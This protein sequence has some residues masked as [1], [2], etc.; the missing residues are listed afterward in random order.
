MSKR[1][2]GE[3]RRRRD[4]HS[5]D[6]DRN[7][8]S[9]LNSPFQSSFNIVDSLDR[10]EK[11][12][13]KKMKE[14]FEKYNKPFKEDILLT[15]EDLSC[16]DENGTWNV[17]SKYGQKNTI[18]QRDV[19]N[20]VQKLKENNN[21]SIVGTVVHGDSGC[22][23]DTTVNIPLKYSK[24]LNTNCN[25]TY[26][27]SDDENDKSIELHSEEETNGPLDVK[28][29]L[30]PLVHLSDTRCGKMYI[31]DTD[32]LLDLDESVSSSKII[33]KRKEG[34]SFSVKYS[35]IKIRR[36]SNVDG[37]RREICQKYIEN[38]YCRSLDKSTLEES[39]F[40][41]VKKFIGRHNNASMLNGT[42]SVQEKN[43]CET[44]D[45]FADDDALNSSDLG[46]VSLADYYPNMIECLS[47]LMDFPRKEM[48]AANIIRY[49]RHHFWFAN[50]HKLDITKAKRTMFRARNLKLTIGSNPKDTPY[51]SYA[52]TSSI[53]PMVMDDFNKSGIIE[54]RKQNVSTRYPDGT[55][56]LD[57][58]K[59]HVKSPVVLETFIF[60]NDKTSKFGE[61]RYTVPENVK[62][63]NE[64]CTG[65][66][67]PSSLL[68]RNCMVE[69]SPSKL[70]PEAWVK[71][72]HQMKVASKSS[73]LFSPD[74]CRLLKQPHQVQCT[75]KRRHS[76]ST[77]PSQQ[78]SVGMPLNE[79]TAF[80]TLYKKL[81]MQDSYPKFLPTHARHHLSETVNALI[82]SPGSIRGKR[83]ANEDFSV[84]NFKRFRMSG[85][86]EPIVTNSQYHFSRNWNSKPSFSPQMKN[87]SDLG[88]Y[89]DSTRLN[90]NLG[91]RSFS[92]RIM[93]SRSSPLSELYRGSSKSLKMSSPS[94][95]VNG[96][97]KSVHRKLNYT[98]DCG[99]TAGDDTVFF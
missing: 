52:K 75:L 68:V 13:Q 42:L 78:V 50:K 20:K 5:E 22:Y 99:S 59:S 97:R 18:P 56:I 30:I 72:N 39:F 66:S 31:A 6:F 92:P 44:I 11:I 14:I 67:H 40:M 48:A 26:I 19:Q 57:L 4:R 45:E 74:K 60:N 71:M 55:K 36:D 65:L 2:L 86:F 29:S 12:F 38:D 41:Q 87:G 69:K 1:R 94:K 80:E 7:P 51:T 49:Y 35:P 79:S 93:Q 98:Y 88:E 17:N 43:G 32:M 84:S 89:Q 16:I 8:R 25:E 9:D 53:G 10:N 76:F 63:R 61:N 85:S 58:S 81:V 3:D 54:Y 90:K 96:I 83:L 73:V 21:L 34:R 28:K 91:V 46:N 70:I 23:M 64:L 37:S 82:N 33:I 95:S 77:L 27:L 15:L 24:V 47:R 62:Q